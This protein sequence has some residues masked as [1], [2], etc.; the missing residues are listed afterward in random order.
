[1]VMTEKYYNGDKQVSKEE[2][3]KE[4]RLLLADRFRDVGDESKMIPIEELDY[5]LGELEKLWDK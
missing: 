3:D 5:Y 2:F 1:M 4:R